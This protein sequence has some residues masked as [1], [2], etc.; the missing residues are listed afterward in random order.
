M[1]N[2]YRNNK[3]LEALKYSNGKTQEDIVREVID[4][5]KE[6][7]KIIFIKGLCGTGKS[8][9]ALNLA[10]EIG[11]TSIVVPIKSLQEQYES[12]YTN[13]MYLIKEGKKLKI[14]VITGRNNHICLFNNC[15]ADNNKIPCTIEIKEENIDKLKEY[16]KLNRFVNEEDFRDIK[17]VRRF[18]IAPVCPYWSPVLPSE[19]KVSIFKDCKLKKYKG[20]YNV[21]YTIYKREEGCSYYN[22][23]ESYVDSDV[24][25][26]NSQKYELENLMNRK[27]ATELEI[28]DECDRF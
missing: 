6:G 25:I 24:I 12:D 28:I 9:I 22:Q 3:F 7:H 1:W 13:N 14:N 20:I 16:I 21:E 2:L 11:K 19:F 4:A 23:F 27:P 10:R 17:D 8:A 15:R 18:S 26:F 5:I